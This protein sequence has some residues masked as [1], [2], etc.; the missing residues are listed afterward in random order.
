MKRMAL[1]HLLLCGSLLLAAGCGTGEEGAG[2]VPPGFTT[3]HGGELHDFD[4]LIGAWTTRQQRLKVRNSGSGE[5]VAAP[6]N[7]H[8]AH[9]Y[10]DG[11]AIVEESRSPDAAPAGLFIYAFDRQRSQW[12][13]Y[14]LNAK[15]GQL[16]PPL[17]GGFV[18]PRGEFYADD[19]DG[20]RA[21]RVRVVWTLSDRDHARWEQA[22]SYD[23]RTW[24]TNWISEFTRSADP[25][26]CSAERAP[27]DG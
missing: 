26:G 27:A 2:S 20:R 12:S 8:C 23:N 24:E 16:D 19:H 21:I 18:G 5:W 11:G 13:I 9:R 25:G 17:V 4:Y 7:S 22:F 6:A 1:R 3:Q 14:W 15:T 10:L